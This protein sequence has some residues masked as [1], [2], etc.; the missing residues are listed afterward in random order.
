MAV[1]RLLINVSPTRRVLH[2]HQ[3][4]ALPIAQPY[5]QNPGEDNGREYRAT[6]DPRQYPI[7][8]CLGRPQVYRAQRGSKY[9]NSDY[10]YESHS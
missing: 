7:A 5:S 9:D 1:G 6:H 3:T 2:I 10:D 8:Q 4:P